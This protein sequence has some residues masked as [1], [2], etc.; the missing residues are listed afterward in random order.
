MP[1]RKIIEPVRPTATQVQQIRRT[2]EQSACVHLAVASL[3]AGRPWATTRFPT[4]PRYLS[5]LRLAYEQDM[6]NQF[7]EILVSYFADAYR[8]VPYIPIPERGR[9]AC[10]QIAGLIEK[11][12]VRLVGGTI[13]ARMLS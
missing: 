6:P 3:I 4:Y 12:G 8:F 2:I 7:M 9:D 11:Y 13:L 1:K 10:Q 5:T